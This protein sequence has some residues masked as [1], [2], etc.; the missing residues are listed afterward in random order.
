MNPGIVV[1]KR[2]NIIEVESAFPIFPNF[3][4]F[5]LTATIDGQTLFTLPSYPL[6]SGLMVMNINGVTQDPLNG[7][8]TINGNVM[9]VH[10]NISVDDRI[11]GFYQAL[12]SSI[13]P[14][15]LNYRSFFFTAIQDQTQFNIGFV[16]KQII[17]IS[18]NGTLQSLENGDYTVNGQTITMSQSLD[19]GDK[20]FGL[21]IQ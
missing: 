4:N 8:Y 16:P 13:N 21:A 7:D 20:F 1:I 10:S 9:T 19:A 18:I 17:Y 6:L 14:S 2:D 15:N 5:S 11:S 12:P 3:Q